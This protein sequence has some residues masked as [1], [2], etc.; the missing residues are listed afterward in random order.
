MKTTICIRNNFWFSISLQCTLLCTSIIA[1]SQPFPDSYYHAI[2]TVDSLIITKQYKAAALRYDSIFKSYGNRGTWFYQ[3]KAAHVWNMAGNTD[4]AFY[5]LL[6]VANQKSYY[7][8]NAALTNKDFDNLH[9]DSRWNE[10]Q[11]TLANNKEYLENVVPIGY[12]R[13]HK[14]GF[15]IL[16]SQFAMQNYRAATDSALMALDADLNRIVNLG[17]KKSAL[18]AI[19][20]VRI[21]LDWDAGYSNPNPQVHGSEDWLIQNGT[22]PE[23]VRQLDIPNMR[24]YIKLRNQNQPL[25]ILHE[26]SHTYHFKLTDEQQERIRETYLNAMQKNLYQSVKYSHG[27]GTYDFNVEAY[28]TTDEYEY[29]AE[30]VTAYFGSSTYYPFN[31]KDLKKYDQAGYKLVKALWVKQ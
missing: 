17:I 5:Y 20:G 26:F 27:D 22:I 16:V 10:F 15:E 6:K 25:V 7:A 8:V 12:N 31:R 1:L 30:I 21:F 19:K 29:F 9:A 23:K 3:Y 2:S 13:I 24:T 28:A 4:S 11:L 14:Y 18:T